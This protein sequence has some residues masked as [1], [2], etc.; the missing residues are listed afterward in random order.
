MNSWALITSW[1]RRPQYCTDLIITIAI[2]VYHQLLCLPRV[3]NFLRKHKTYI[4]LDGWGR[5]PNL[6]KARECFRE[7]VCM[8]CDP[9]IVTYGIMVD[10]LCKAGRVDEAE[11]VVKEMDA[12][13]CNATSFI[14]SVLVHTYGV[15]NRIEDAINT[16]IEMESRGLK[17]DVV[18]YNALIGAFCKANKFKNV[19]RVL[20][21]M[22]SNGVDP[23]SR[24]CNVIISG[25]ISQGETDRA[26]R[27]FRRMVKSCEPDAD[28][29][30]MLIK[31]FSERN[32]LEIAMKFGI[33]INGLCQKGNAMKACVLM[34]EMIENGTRPSGSTFVKL[35]QLLI[36]EGREDV[37]K[38][39]HEKVDLKECIVIMVQWQRHF[40]PVFRQIAHS[41]TTSSPQGK[42]LTTLT[43]RTILLPSISSR[44]PVYH[45]FQYQGISGSTCLLSKSSDLEQT[46]TSSPLALTS[47]L[48]SKE[49]QD[50][51]QTPV[52]KERVQA[53]MSKIKQSPKK[54]NLVAALVRGMLVK[55]ALLQLQ[56]TVKRA[57]RTVYQGITQAQG[58]AVNNHGLDAE[59][60]IVAE[61]FVGKG[62]FRKKVSYH[63][64]GRAGIK[65]KPE[66]RLTV[67]VRE[68][69][70][71]EEAKIARLKVHNFRK[72]TK[73]EKRLVP[74]QLIVSNPVWGRKNKS[75]DRNSSATAA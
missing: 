3:F 16:F 29:Y 65:V 52:K 74:H 8:G 62:L 41:A 20:Q 32:E 30:T 49:A 63:S 34:E 19:H 1:L 24:T 57:S 58:N 60:L 37:L 21:E 69:T 50:Q 38:F 70:A 14:H 23:N 31:M 64:K 67:V 59:R 66:C 61:A 46:P 11:E 33:L 4:L 42:G 48:G 72:L 73:R 27:V 39:L 18:V 25:L 43:A 12:N 68:I 71:E 7:M 53:V 40:L 28:T 13:N 75:S 56:V 55:D 35:R 10:I 36:K 44:S 45:S 2:I 6:P 15:E 51:K 5:A 47:F 9:D 26:F 54:V 22:E 17:P